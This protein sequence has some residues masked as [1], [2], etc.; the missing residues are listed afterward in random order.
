MHGKQNSWKLFAEYLCNTFWRSSETIFSVLDCWILL[1]ILDSGH[2]IL[3]ERQKSV[4]VGLADEISVKLSSR[5]DST[6]SASIALG[7]KC[8]LCGCC[9]LCYECA[10]WIGSLDKSRTCAPQDKKESDIGM[11]ESKR[12]SRWLKQTILRILRSTPSSIVLAWE[13]N[14]GR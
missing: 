5:Q 4:I 1:P 7:F 12:V 10:S 11:G 14:L 6:R 13:G 9:S 8:H 3:G 2:E